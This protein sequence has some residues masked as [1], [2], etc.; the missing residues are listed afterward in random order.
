MQPLSQN[1]SGRLES[2]NLLLLNKLD[3]ICQLSSVEL[4]VSILKSWRLQGWP[5]DFAA[6]QWQIRK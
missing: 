4:T 1:F 2:E 5:S 6:E 3:I